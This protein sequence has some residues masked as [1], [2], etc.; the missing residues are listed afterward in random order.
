ML[1]KIIFL[2]VLSA[3]ATLY[4]AQNNQWVHDAISNKLKKTLQATWDCKLD[5]Q[6]DTVNLFVPSVTLKNVRVRPK[7]NNPLLGLPSGALAQDEWHWDAQYL[8][9]SSSWIICALSS[10]IGLD[11]EV[12]TAHGHTTVQGSYIPLIHDH[13]MK[14]MSGASLD[15]PVYIK[16]LRFLTSTVHAQN[17]QSGIDFEFQWS[18]ESKSINGMFKTVAFVHDG[19]VRSAHKTWC[20]HLQGDVTLNF[21]YTVL[22]LKAESSIHCSA[23]LH[24]TS[25]STLPCAINGSWLTDR[26]DFSIESLDKSLVINPLKIVRASQ[27]LMIDAQAV[28]SLARALSLFSDAPAA[29]TIQG[30]CRATMHSEFGAE[31]QKIEG[32][33][34]LHAITYD[35]FLVSDDAHLTFSYSPDKLDGLLS[36]YYKPLGVLEGSWEWD[37]HKNTGALTIGNKNSIGIPGFSKWAID[38]HKLSLKAEID[39]AHAINA[40]YTVAAGNALTHSQVQSQGKL[41]WHDNLLHCS[42]HINRSVYEGSFYFDPSMILK[43][44]IYKS[45]QGVTLLD[46][47]ET[48]NDTNQFQGTL[49]IGLLRA[50]GQQHLQYDVQGEGHIGLKG[51]IKNRQLHLDVQLNDGLIRL[52]QT[53]N[54]INACRAHIICDMTQKNITINDLHVGLHRGSINSERIIMQ[55]DDAY[56]TQYAYASFTFKSCLFNMKKD[57]FALFS[58]TLAIS[59]QHNQLAHAKGSFV[60]ERSYVKENVYSAQFQKNIAGLTY[61]M[62]DTDK[63]DMSCDL[64]IE[65]KEPIRV[66][67]AFLEANAKV[68]LHIGNTVRDPKISGAIELISGSLAFPYK[69]L[70]ITKGSIYFMEDQLFDPLI[71][72]VAKNKIK[73][74]SIGLHVTGSLLNHHISLESSPPLTDEQ[75]I[76][77]L[78]V[79]SQEQSLNVVMPALLMQNLKSVLF[80]SEQSPLKLNNSFKSWLKPFKNINLVPS[81]SDQTGRGGLRGAIEIEISDRWRAMA[82]KN[83]SLSEDTRFEVEYSLSDDIT[84]RG[85]RNERKDVATEVEMRWKFGR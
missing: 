25:A 36:L 31:H 51:S 67:T 1:K 53:Y 23:D 22:G 78:L 85:I 13:V 8:T 77:L 38:V 68:A 65:T 55:W 52:P 64:S 47:H 16:S 57:L 32:T 14:M 45:S 82:Q 75:I 70:L 24:T 28:A 73:N 29:R 49:D 84:L 39:P 83:F 44:L 66:D 27:G 81:F 3:I 19:G 20:D 71:E 17:Q 60:V 37:N 9:L 2:L 46:I 50:L 80:D 54:F 30:D 48:K 43:K 5:F 63:Q 41:Y 35:S 40:T 34:D 61:L 69:P 59:K 21:V 26:G 4:F 11:L 58:G 76:A 74:Y 62:V 42:G 79:G 12:D 33:C 72:L 10:I 18:S 7:S 56:A 15:I 6:V